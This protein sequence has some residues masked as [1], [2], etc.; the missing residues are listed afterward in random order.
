M[1]DLYDLPATAPVPATRRPIAPYWWLAG[2]GG[3]AL[4]VGA[5]AAIPT[6]SAHDDYVSSR[7][8]DASSR[9][10]TWAAVSLTGLGVGGAALLGALVWGLVASPTPSVTVVP[11]PSGLAI[12]GVL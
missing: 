4:L 10:A 5:G 1:A 12:A 6:K 2:A 7:G 11:T 3:V 9:H 8:V